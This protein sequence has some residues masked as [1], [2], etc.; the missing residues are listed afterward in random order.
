[1]KLNER[2]FNLIDEPWIRVMDENCKVVEVSLL[3][4]IINAHK[5]K[6][7]S[8]ELPTQDVAVMRLILAVIHT[9]VS[10]YDE[11]GDEND[12]EDSED[13]A[14]DRWK[15]LW[16]QGYFP[17]NAVRE[18]LEQWH[19][20]FWLFH[21]DRPFYQISQTAMD[22][23]IT[24]QKRILLSK[25]NGEISES[26]NKINFF[27]IASGK[28]KESL[29]Y[30]EAT[31]WLISMNSFD[32][33]FIK[34]Q[35]KDLES[36]SVGWVGSLGVTYLLGNNLFETLMLNLVLINK[37]DVECEQNPL[38]EKDE[39]CE[40][41]RVKIGMPNNSAELYT[42]QSRR[43]HLYRENG[44][45]KFFHNIAGDLLSVDNA[46][47]EPMT[48][49]HIANKE[50]T[51]SK[52]MKHNA[53]TQMWR[54][55]S[56]LYQKEKNQR[57]GVVEWYKN[58]LY[59]KGLIKKSVF[60]K[61]AIVAVE[62]DTSS[63]HKIINYFSDSL[64]MHSE[65]LSDI[66]ANWRSDI[67]TEIQHCESLAYEIGKFAQNLYVASGGDNSPKNK[68]FTELPGKVK[69]QLYYRLDMPFR[70]W[71]IS[72]NPATMGEDK[73]KKIKEWQDEARKIA[74]DYADE[75]MDNTA[76]CAFIGHIIKG[77]KKNEIY[78]APKAR[79]IFIGNVKKIY[80]G[81]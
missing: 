55:F 23:I 70:K 7:L 42:I 12:L 37:D 74:A 38:W 17:E 73:N 51:V 75:L 26:A 60:L 79:N 40:K 63:A 53:P 3:D 24:N 10:R 64:S 19:E 4:A 41:E 18:Y 56:V 29:N 9:V 14:L 35:G 48:I 27:S 33:T 20:R 59:G 34:P 44:E 76:E 25:F 54:E 62:Y 80:E 22:S 77:E 47:R 6:S 69:E 16:E 71:L 46:F 32:D 67:E 11:Y 57:A 8:G 68:T 21:P 72:I 13:D 30:S 65:I 2:E 78:S 15:G 5:Y 1:M 52:P 39:I 81:K 36:A 43:V 58:Y 28:E 50:G 45:I 61:T 31:R 49:W 66:G